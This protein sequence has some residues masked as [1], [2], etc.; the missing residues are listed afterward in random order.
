MKVSAKT[1]ILEILS[2]NRGPVP[3]RHLVRAAGVFG[4]AENSVRVAIVRLRAEGL[5]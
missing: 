3:V 2:A 4:V 5:V 1:V